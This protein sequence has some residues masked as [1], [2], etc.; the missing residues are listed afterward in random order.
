MYVRLAHEV[1]RKLSEANAKLCAERLGV[2]IN[3][4]AYSATR[5]SAKRTLTL[6]LH[7]LRFF[8]WE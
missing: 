6:F 7:Y 5:V 2:K 3:H 1:K 4:Q 8:R